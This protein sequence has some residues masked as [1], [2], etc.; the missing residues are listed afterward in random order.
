[1]F[2]SSLLV[3][4]ITG[5][6]EDDQVES[7][8]GSH[9]DGIVTVVAGLHIVSLPAQEEHVGLEQLHLVVDPKNL[10]HSDAF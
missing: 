9:V 10:N 4:I 2:S 8:L 6:V 1:M 3:T 5:V 7:P